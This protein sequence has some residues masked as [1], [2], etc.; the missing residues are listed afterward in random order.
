MSKTT[1]QIIIEGL[2][3]AGKGGFTPEH[4]RAVPLADAAPALLA[5]C[6]ATVEYLNVLVSLGGHVGPD[7]INPPPIYGL[8]KELR[9]AIADA[10]DN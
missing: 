1:S 4:T 10:L 3:Q 5:A 6:K 2:E 9:A 7:A 8:I